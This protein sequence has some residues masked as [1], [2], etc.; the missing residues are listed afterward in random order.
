MCERLA[1]PISVSPDF[2]GSGVGTARRPYT[3]GLKKRLLLVHQRLQ[4]PGGSTA[5]AA[6]TIEVLKDDYEV[7]LL[8]ETE[9]DVAGVDRFY[10]TSLGESNLSVI[11]L[12]R[13]AR[14]VFGLDP[15]QASIQP[16][17]YLMRLSRRYRRDYDAVI[18]TGT[19]EMDLGGPG[20]NYVHYPYLARFWG[21]YRDSGAGWMGCLRGETKPWMLLAGIRVERLK[22][23]TLLANS[24]WTGRQVEN[25]YG[26]RPRTLY[27]PVTAPPRVLD[28]EA[29]EE[30]FVTAGRLHVAKRMDWILSVLG[31]VRERRPAIRLHLV[32]TREPGRVGEA[33]YAGL[34]KLVDENRDWVQ[35]HEDLPR[36]DLLELMGRCR[37][38]IHAL[39]AEHFGIAPAEALMAGCVP[40]VHNSGGQVEIVGRD[41]RLCYEDEEATEKISAVLGDRATLTA[42]REMLAAQREL[43]TVERFRIGMRAA[44][45]EVIAASRR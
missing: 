18:A 3:A 11:R 1:L 32:G 15:D 31:K 37:Y 8:T 34:R 7:T 35:L 23:S 28:W 12:S 30:G 44:V 21:K 40:F 16:V 29:R 33:F 39:R 13:A 24:D 4:P 20:V 43:F 2:A 27:P 19:E 17:A 9:P 42:L 14:F 22:Q 5:V 45:E 26:I 38:A 36:E 6:W 41:P 10:G 25:G